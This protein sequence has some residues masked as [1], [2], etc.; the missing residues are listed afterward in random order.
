M[1]KVIWQSRSSVVEESFREGRISPV[2]NGGNAY[3]IQASLALRKEFDISVSGAAVQLSAE[4]VFSYWKRMRKLQEK[5]DV[6]IREP[7]PLV[8]GRK[9]SK[10]PSVAV[11]H[12]I[13]DLLGRSSLKHRWYFSR[14]K[15][16]L[17]SVSLVITVSR[18]WKD[19]LE[20]MGCANVRIIYNSFDPAE[21]VRNSA[22]VQKFKEKFNIPEGRPLLYAG[23]ANR[24]KGVY[25]VYEALKNTGY[26]ILISGNMNQAADLPV[27]YLRL[28]R[29][30]YIAMLHACDLVVT[31][32]KMPEGW[33]RIAH[34]ALLCGTPVIGSGT[35][36]MKELLTGAGQV[37]V[38]NPDELK[39]AV[40][41]V[42]NHAE[43]YSSNGKKFVEQ[44]DMKYFSKEWTKAVYSLL[45]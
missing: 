2:A 37:I 45:P 42:M 33:N 21:Y 5:A 15:K 36:G 32:S 19:Y 9:E 12:H 28:E 35:G 41:E 4:S 31:M 6:I 7:Y 1:K 24:Q 25:E 22:H 23:N 14:L 20:S 18:Y 16:R 3:D 29:D 11:I 39:G 40:D 38:E 17:R 43:S 27:Q 44:F 26:H 13:D 34:E 10:I 8:F 30:D